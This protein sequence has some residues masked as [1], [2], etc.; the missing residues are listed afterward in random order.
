MA[1]RIPKTSLLRNRD[2]D[3]RYKKP[4]AQEQML[5]D[6]LTVYYNDPRMGGDLP[7][8]VDNREAIRKDAWSLA[9]CVYYKLSGESDPCSVDSLEI[10]TNAVCGRFGIPVD[11]PAQPRGRSRNPESSSTDLYWEACRTAGNEL[12]RAQ[13]RLKDAEQDHRDASVAAYEIAHPAKHPTLDFYPI[14]SRKTAKAIAE[15]DRRRLAVKEAQHAVT[16][17]EH[18]VAE[19]E[20]VA[21]DAEARLRGIE[22]RRVDKAF[23]IQAARERADLPRR[24]A[25]E[26]AEQERYAAEKIVSLRRLEEQRV[27]LEEMVRARGG[28]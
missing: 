8:G 11:A 4:T 21:V 18:A 6:M 3:G 19:A 10:I 16:E 22:P 9:E 17:A 23:F 15:A 13:R 1:S 12:Y 28:R 14:D 5:I 24:E 7:H 25:A 2:E 20:R 27:R 26:R